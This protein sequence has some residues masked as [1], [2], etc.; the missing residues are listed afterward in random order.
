ML[1]P[2]FSNFPILETE[3]LLLRRITPADAEAIFL[4]RS[5]EDVMKY[6]DKEKAKDISEGFAFVQ[7]IDDAITKNDGINW[8][9]SLKENPAQLIGVIGFW[10]LIKEHYRAEVGYTLSPS[11]WGR[12]VMS[13]ALRTCIDYGF[14]PLKLHSIEAHINP[15]NAA[16]AA[17]LEKTGFVKEAYFREDYFFKGEFRDTVIYSLLTPYR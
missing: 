7:R 1:T 16:S 15:D 10:R 12:G 2:D 8:G 6:I 5:N 9:I 13:E 3:R 4:L 11:H 14:G 17:I